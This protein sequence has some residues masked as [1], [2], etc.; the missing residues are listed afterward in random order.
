[1]RLKVNEVLA[2]FLLHNEFPTTIV[3]NAVLIVAA[4]LIITYAKRIELKSQVDKQVEENKEEY[5]NLFDVLIEGNSQPTLIVS[6]DCEL[7]L[8]NSAA[9]NEL[10]LLDNDKL[11]GEFGFINKFVHGD[12]IHYQ[13]E[14]NLYDEYYL[15]SMSKFT[16][17]V[18]SGAFI[19]FTK[20]THIKAAQEQQVSFVQ[21]ASHELKTPISAIQGVCELLLDGKV[22]DRQK[23]KEFIM[24][25]SKENERLKNIVSNLTIGNDIKLRYQKFKIDDLFHEIR[26]I[27][28][29]YK[30]DEN[31]KIYFKIINEIKHEIKHDEAKIMQI[32]IN[33]IEN[34]YK[35]TDE[36]TI[37]LRAY[38]EANDICF[39]VSDTGIGI[40]EDEVRSVFKR[41][42]RV[43]KSRSRETGG[44]GL[45]LNIVKELVE[46]LGG[47]IE[48]T[49][50]VNKGTRFKVSLRAID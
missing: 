1:M 42:Y 21:N 31:H 23:V 35:Y 14:I 49:S 25:I 10:G 47:S 13:T 37:T 11:G 5:N 4:F 17:S 39:S 28:R 6:D 30:P 12:N 19:N 40:N 20:I 43:D 2:I 22:Q 29:N 48:V 18:L 16:S 32:L 33:L 26:I 50:N 24:L 7:Y 3:M 46:I 45:G 9:I 41:F 15:V 34:A 27:F 36:G 38:R 44:S 8:Q